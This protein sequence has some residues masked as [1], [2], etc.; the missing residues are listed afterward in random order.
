MPLPQGVRAFYYRAAN[1]KVTRLG[2]IEN[3]PNGVILSP[4][5]KT[6]YV[7][8]SMQAEMLA[9]PVEGPGKLGPQR[10]FCS[11]KQALQ[12]GRRRRRPDNRQQG[13]VYITSALGIQVFSPRG[14]PWGSLSF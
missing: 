5:E 11:L 13:N 7:I 3:A 4:D 2:V 9:Y 1:G 10:T 12:D 8:P 14:R 6:L